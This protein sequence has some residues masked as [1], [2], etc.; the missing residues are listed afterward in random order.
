[1]RALM[2]SVIGTLLCL[3]LVSTATA[4]QPSPEAGPEPL[5]LTRDEAVAL[6]LATDPR[7]A[8]LPDFRRLEIERSAN[9]DMGIILGSDYYRVLPTLPTE[10]SGLGFIDFHYPGNWL[11]EV[12][13][14]RDCATLYDGDGP[15]SET[16]PLPDPCE[17][18]HSWFYRV[19]PDGAVS[20]LFDEG[21]E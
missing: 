11:I 20:L 1:M 19:Q 2:S 21:D 9:F 10:F 7:Y 12:T 16:P 8:D 17:W 3:T 13:L 6:V 5:G 18:R 14:V 4:A 15:S